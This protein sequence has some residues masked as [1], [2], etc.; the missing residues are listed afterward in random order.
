MVGHRSDYKSQSL[1]HEDKAVLTKAIA[2][3]EKDGGHISFSMSGKRWFNFK[4]DARDFAT[5][6]AV[7]ETIHTLPASHMLPLLLDVPMNHDSDPDNDDCEF[8][9][10]SEVLDGE[11]PE[12]TGSRIHWLSNDRRNKTPHF[13]SLL[14]AKGGRGHYLTSDDGVRVSGIH[15]RSPTDNP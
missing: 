7:M 5:W 3:A 8:S 2:E 15:L 10:D 12:I 4:Q 6:S 14:Y 13:V 9:G 1:V 11:S